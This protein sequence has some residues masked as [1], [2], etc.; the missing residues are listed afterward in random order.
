MIDKIPIKTYTHKELAQ[1]Y[2]VDPDTLTNWIRRFA[3][4]MKRCG[5]HPGKR[6]YTIRQVELIFQELGNP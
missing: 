2:N 6:I 1:F 5:W 4:K 3:A